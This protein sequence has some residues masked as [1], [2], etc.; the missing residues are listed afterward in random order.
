MGMSIWQLAIIAVIVILLF[1]T[2]KLR[3]IGGDFG[4]AVKGFKNAMDDSDAPTAT[5]EYSSDL[6]LG[7]EV[8]EHSS[9][10]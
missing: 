2:K 5:S 8:E 7:Y 4:G 6:S 1:G 9:S 3:N 10:K